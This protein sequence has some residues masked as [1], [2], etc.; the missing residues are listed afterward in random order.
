MC[1]ALWLG[2][3]SAYMVASSTNITSNSE[4]GNHWFCA[5]LIPVKKHTIVCRRDGNSDLLFDP[6][7]VYF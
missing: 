2:Q 5:M 4:S 1:V 7:K 6:A 3:V